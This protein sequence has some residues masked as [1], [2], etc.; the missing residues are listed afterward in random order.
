MLKQEEIDAHAWRT[1]RK[2]VHN[3]PVAETAQQKM[4]RIKQEICLN[5]EY[6]LRQDYARNLMDQVTRTK[7]KAIQASLGE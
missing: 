4:Y 5:L 1:A 2:I 6:C 7:P 3:A